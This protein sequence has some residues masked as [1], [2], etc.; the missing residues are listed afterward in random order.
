MAVPF[1]TSHVIKTVHV[2]NRAGNGGK[3]GSCDQLKACVGAFDRKNTC[4]ASMR[5]SADPDQT[6]EEQSDLGLQRFLKAFLMVGIMHLFFIQYHLPGPVEVVF[7][8]RHQLSI[9]IASRMT[10]KC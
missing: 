1:H 6:A 4:K 7:D 3:W 2:I 9:Q 5:N 8:T 10:S